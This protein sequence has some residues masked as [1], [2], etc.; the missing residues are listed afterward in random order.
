MKA[1]EKY[2]VVMNCGGGLWDKVVKVKCSNKYDY[3]ACWSN[4]EAD[5]S[6]MGKDGPPDDERCKYH[7]FNTKQEAQTFF[8]GAKAFRDFIGG[9]LK[10]G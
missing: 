1:K 7:V 2:V 4:D 9:F 10:A 8:E 5:I 6:W 3:G